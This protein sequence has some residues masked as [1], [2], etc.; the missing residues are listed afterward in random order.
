MQA[1]LFRFLESKMKRQS[2]AEKRYRIFSVSSFENSLGLLVWRGALVETARGIG[3]G[4]RLGLAIELETE[5]NCIFG[6]AGPWL[7]Q[8]EKN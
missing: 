7:W 2:P 1:A 5:I 4:V 8:S 6:F 3:I